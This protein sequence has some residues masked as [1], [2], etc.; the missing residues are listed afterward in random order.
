MFL[1]VSSLIMR[2]FEK[3]AVSMKLLI[4]PLE[5]GPFSQIKVYW[6]HMNSFILFQVKEKLI[7]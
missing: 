6:S 7:H 2:F 5:M 3:L 4:L 1:N